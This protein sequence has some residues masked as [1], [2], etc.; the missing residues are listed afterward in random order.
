MSNPQRDSSAKSAP[1]NDNKTLFS[2]A[3]KAGAI[4]ATIGTVETVPYKA[5]WSAL[6]S[7]QQIL[8]MSRP[9]PRVTSLPARRV[10]SPMSRPF[11][12]SHPLL[13]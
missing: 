10:L 2:A 1:Q 11:C 6:P 3:A 5:F 4:R 8:A 9:L 13:R 12:M 7:A